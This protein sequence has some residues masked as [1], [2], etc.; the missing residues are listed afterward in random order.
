M[1]EDWSR[2]DRVV[3]VVIPHHLQALAGL[4]SEVPVRVR[5]E[6]GVATVRTVLDALEADHPTLRGTIRDQRTGAR[7]AYLRFFAG[8]ED[9]SHEPPD[10][11]LPVKVAEGDEIFR[12]LGAIAGG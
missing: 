7:R 10:A 6:A 12:V 3:R 8:G 5:D 2:E 4:D 11:P 1:S 9:W